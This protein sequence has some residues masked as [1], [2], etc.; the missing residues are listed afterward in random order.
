M[1]WR[2][3][4]NQTDANLDFL[5]L[6]EDWTLVPDAPIEPNSG[7][8][9]ALFALV[10][11]ARIGEIEQG[12]EQMATPALGWREHNSPDGRI[13]V[14]CDGEPIATIEVDAAILPLSIC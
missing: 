6:S 9:V 1:A 4:E 11:P 10:T 5:H 3:P 7:S 12:Q 13:Y 2:N 14:Q 8:R